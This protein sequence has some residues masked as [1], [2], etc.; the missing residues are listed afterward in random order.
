MTTII[1]AI[2]RQINKPKLPTHILLSKE[3]FKFLGKDSIV[4]C[5]QIKTIDKRRF[6]S[7]KVT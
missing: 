5:E 6:I 7:I 3:K 4:M 2:T 1:V